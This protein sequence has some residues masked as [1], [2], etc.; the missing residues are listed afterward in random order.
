MIVTRL[1]GGLGNQMF[2]YAAGKNS[3]QRLGVLLALD[4]SFLKQEPKAWAKRDFELDVFQLKP[5]FT[6]ADEVAAFL[7]LKEKR[8]Y[9]VLKRKLPGLF[10]RNCFVEK[11]T[12]FDPA[13]LDLKDNT[14]LDG[15]WQSE[16]YF[17]E[18]ESAIRADFTFRN[19]PEGRN[20]EL[21]TEITDKL[22]I[23]IHVR[24]GDY[25]KDPVTNAYH[26]VCS[27]DYYLKALSVLTARYPDLHCFV[28]S[29]DA[30]WVKKNLTF[31][32][33]MTCVSHNTGKDSYLDMQLMSLCRHQVIANSSF[34]WWAAW[35]NTNKA[36]TVIA[37][38]KW[39]A[40]PGAEA[41]DIYPES[42][43]RL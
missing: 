21:A 13:F 22:S 16:R 1:K 27:T 15:F 2:Q 35:L 42:W 41:P 7:K 39:Y 6:P 23:G 43:I 25:V 32:P 20:A 34:S 18:N 29:D 26:G 40:K 28:F 8:L 5:N 33:N 4:L 30:G 3:A 19:I 9:R 37:P 17:K 10:S 38:E 14:L 31:L 36:K 24:R 11:S 12:R